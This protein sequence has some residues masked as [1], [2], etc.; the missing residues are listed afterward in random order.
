MK[1]LVLER[2]ARSQPGPHVSKRAAQPCQPWAADGC[3]RRE[4]PCLFSPFVSTKAGDFSVSG[5]GPFFGISTSW[6]STF[7]YPVR[8]NIPGFWLGQNGGS[9]E[10]KEMKVFSSPSS[11]HAWDAGVSFRVLSVQIKMKIVCPLSR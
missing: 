6:A 5:K 7:V 4:R 3:R 1:R 10:N 8:T 2:K 11:S 9:K